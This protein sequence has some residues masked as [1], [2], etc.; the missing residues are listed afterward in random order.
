MIS[1][2]KPACSRVAGEVLVWHDI[3]Y[4]GPRRLGWREEEILAARAEFAAGATAAACCRASMPRSTFPSR[5]AMEWRI[6]SAVTAGKSRVD[7]AKLITHPV[8]KVSAYNSIRPTHVLL[9]G[10]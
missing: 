2:V 1:P 5:Q 6:T 9:L 10:G 4:D 3:L 8:A 7:L